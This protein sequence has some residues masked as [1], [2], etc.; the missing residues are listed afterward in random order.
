VIV[1]R[2]LAI[3]HNWALPRVGSEMD[4]GQEKPD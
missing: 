4:N 1:L 3:R 2:L